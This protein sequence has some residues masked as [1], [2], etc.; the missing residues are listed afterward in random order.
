MVGTYTPSSRAAQGDSQVLV[1]QRKLE[2]GGEIVLEEVAPADLHD[3]VA[4]QAAGQDLDQPVGVDAGLGGQHQRLAD[5][6]DGHRDEDLV[7]CLGRLAGARVAHV[8]DG[9]A[10]RIE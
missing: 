9:L 8:H 4:G 7:A 5:R 1:V 6:L 2:P 10:E 3:L